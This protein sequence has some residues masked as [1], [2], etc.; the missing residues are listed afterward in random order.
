M[1][2]EQIEREQV[3][4]KIIGREASPRQVQ[5]TLEAAERL[6]PEL[7]KAYE[8]HY[9]RKLATANEQARQEANKRA[10]LEQSNQKLQDKNSRLENRL[11]AAN[12]R[13]SQVDTQLGVR[14]RAILLEERIK[15]LAAGQG[16]AIHHEISVREL[17]K[18]L[19]G[20]TSLIRKLEKQHTAD[21]EKIKNLRGGALKE[22]LKVRKEFEG[23]LAAARDRE[24]QHAQKLAGR[25]SCIK[26][27]KKEL[28]E[29]RRK[30]LTF[31]FLE[32]WCVLEDKLDRLNYK[33]IQSGK[34]VNRHNQF[35]EAFQEERINEEQ[36]RNLQHMLPQ[37]NDIVHKGHLLTTS[38][39]RE[40]MA[41]LKRV[42]GQL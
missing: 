20:N 23:K 16:K 26:K 11:I 27:I 4:R 17:Q 9:E 40:N 38:Q 14:I 30:V 5:A 28:D 32:I 33:L 8:Q 13:V 19:E 6:Q 36:L 34:S 2:N 1:T 29:S 18:D 41:I 7:L 12:A 21:E 42:I 10:V 3:V 31:D 39:A 15:E 25:N 37:R 22:R 24:N 35:Q